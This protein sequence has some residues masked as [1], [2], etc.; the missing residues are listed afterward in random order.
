[1][2]IKVHPGDSQTIKKYKNLL[3]DQLIFCRQNQDIIVKKAEKLYRMVGK[4]NASGQLK[5][6]CLNWNKLEKILERFGQ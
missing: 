6:R 2:D 5:R 4:K 3:I 1:M